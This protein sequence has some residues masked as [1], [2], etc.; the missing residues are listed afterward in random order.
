MTILQVGLM[1]VEFGVAGCKMQ[2]QGFGVQE[3][4]DLSKCLEFCKRFLDVSSCK[5]PGDF[6]M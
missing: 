6:Y 3:C 5:C 4:P 1:L 2:V